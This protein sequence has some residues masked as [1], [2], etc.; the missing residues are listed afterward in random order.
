MTPRLSPH[1]DLMQICCW[2]RLQPDG[3]LRFVPA[4]RFCDLAEGISGATESGCHALAGDRAPF[5]RRYVPSA[6][7]HASAGSLGVPPCCQF[8]RL[9]DD[10][11]P[12]GAPALPAL[13]AVR[14]CRS[15]PGDCQRAKRYAGPV[16]RST[17]GRCVYDLLDPLG[18]EPHLSGDLLICPSCCAQGAD[19]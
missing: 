6:A 4:Q 10:I 8:A 15:S 12:A 5:G 9:D 13:A 7:P 11:P 18:A 19:A 1:I 16:D 3:N 2:H 17:R 14:C